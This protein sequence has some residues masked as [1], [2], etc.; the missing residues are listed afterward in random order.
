ML[1]ID[2]SYGEG[3]GQIVRYAIA[4]SVLTKKPVEIFN[5][6]KKR[7][8]PGLRPQHHAAISCM[9]SLCNAET[10]G[11]SIGSLKLK[12][13]PEKVQSAEYKFD[14]GTAGSIIL[15][16]QACILSSLQTT[17]PITI[18]LTGGTDVK[19]APSWDY[20]THVFLPLIQ[21]M[22]VTID[23]NLMKRGYYPKGGGEAVLTI[24]P[25]EKLKPLQLKEKQEFNEIKGIIHIANL[26]DHISKRMKHAAMKVA[27][28]N[29]LKSCI[30]IDKA[31]SFSSG[32]GITVWS[33]SDSAVLGSTVL[34]EKG[35]TSEKIGEN[36]ANQLIKEI[37]S[38]STIDTY[39]IDQILPYMII[40]KDETVCRVREL[41]NHTKTNMWLAHQFFKEKKLFEIGNKNGLQVVKV[42]GIGYL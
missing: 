11:L 24:H 13:S 28:K 23:A 12:F 19:W 5:I 26:P 38:G 22:G 32:T 34:G 37:K 16:F 18:K 30:E 27:V 1:Q 36:A 20:F 31:A 14:I 17:G 25:I 35:V 3:G 41:S 42:S 39:A 7:P 29:N 33:K 9:K 8:N 10:E 15:V 40:A 2:G 6:R 21:K 4:L